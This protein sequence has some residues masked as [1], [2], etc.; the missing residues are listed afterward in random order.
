[1]REAGVTSSTLGRVLLVAAR[2]RAQG[3]FDSDWL[4]ACWTCC[5]PTTSPSTW[6]PPP[7]P[8]RPGC[9]TAHP[10]IAARSTV[11]GHT[12]VA[13]Q[14]AALC[15]SSPTYRERALA[16]RRA[17]GHPLPRPPGAGDVARLA[18]STPATTC[19]ATATSAPR[20]S[21]PGCSAATATLDALNEAWGTAFWSQRYTDVRPGAAAAAAATVPNP[22]HGP[23]TA[24]SPPT[25]LLE[26][27]RRRARRAAPPV[28]RRPGHHE[29]HDAEP[30]PA[31]GLLRLG[32]GAGRRQHRPLR[33]GRR[34]RP[35][36]RAGLQRRPDPRLAGGRPWLLM[37]H[38]T[39]AVNW[40]PVNQAKAPGQPCCATAS[41]TSRAAPTRS[42]SSSGGPSQAGRGEV[43]LRAG[44]RTPARTR[45]LWREVV[46]AR[47]GLRPAGRGASAP[48]S[49]RRWRCCGTTTRGWAADRP[50][51]PS[52][53]VDVRRRRRTRSTAPLL[54]RGITADVVHPAADL[55]ATAWSSSPRSTSSRTTARQ[56]RCTR[57]PTRGATVLVTYFSG[58]VDEQRRT[59]GSAATPARSATCSACASR[60]SPRCC[61]A[62]RSRLD[63]G[64][65]ATRLDRAPA[66]GRT[67]RSLAAY[68]DGPAARRPGADPQ[69]GRRRVPP[70]TS[71]PGWTRTSLGTR[72]CDRLVGRGR[73]AARGRGA[74]HRRRGRSGVGPPQR[75]CA[76]PSH[77]PHRRSSP[78]DRRERARPGR[79]T[80]RWPASSPS[81]PARWPSS[82][83]EA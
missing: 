61:P 31:P 83:S 13:R 20:A 23:T 3:E 58:I 8:R 45:R 52:S 4:D 2:A 74:A 14:P 39:S 18:T 82:E 56:P 30:L 7:P 42:A 28:P 16:A 27:L 24:G 54:L 33:G 48:A 34:A 17:P 43:P 40:Q 53:L 5:T 51:H 77:Q 12:A 15:P 67:P 19:P 78:D 75:R 80:R 49:S 64:A 29:L 25:T 76:L 70:G 72:S 6:P 79:P 81:L 55:T 41:P 68:A 11:D 65:T 10:E 47:R 35:A 50:S 38:S 71:A 69:R 37:E 1:M 46:A 60:S 36:S 62:S 66:P 32:A 44:A 73:R 26:L 63:D 59:S 21:A 22:T 57:R 9:S